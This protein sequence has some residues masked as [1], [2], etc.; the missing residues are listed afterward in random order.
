VK[1]ATLWVVAL[2]GV[3]LAGLTVLQARSTERAR[4]DVRPAEAPA[5][6]V[7]AEGRVVAYPG[8]EVVVG[9]ERA[10][11]LV[12]LAL[13]EGQAVRRGDLIAELDSEELRAALAEDRARV[14]EA[15]ADVRLAESTLKRRAELAAEGV[16]A[17]HDLDQAQRDLD[18]ARARLETARA[19]VGRDEA[20][21]RK[22]R[23]LAPISGTVTGRHAQAG[24]TLE[25]G[26]RVFTLADLTRLRIEAEADEADADALGTGAPVSI[27]CEAFPGRAWRGRVEDIPR[28][29]TLRRLKPQDPSRPTDTRILAV[30]V[31]F[32][33]PTP[34]KLG[35]TVELKIDAP[36]PR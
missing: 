34:L 28:S 25:A 31:A 33:E 12:R 22:T 1:N 8:R 11:R 17:A 18:I 14:T 21:L 3:G 23:I 5:R 19:A 24:E 32:A 35:A 2:A 16:I 15:Q 4:S 13:E 30:K 20:Q 7:A 29:V 36:A 9:T 26:Q 10:G 6:R 27:T